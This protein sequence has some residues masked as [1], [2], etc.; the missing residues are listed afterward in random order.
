MR[1][2]LFVSAFLLP[3]LLWAQEKDC[4]EKPAD[5]KSKTPIQI[6]TIH[7]IDPETFDKTKRLSYIYHMDELPI[8]D[9]KKV[10]G[11]TYFYIEKNNCLLIR[12]VDE[13]IQ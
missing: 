3:A 12:H 9:R 5:L 4:R 8:V 13:I 10:K 6:D 11:R 7:V 1:V 2:L